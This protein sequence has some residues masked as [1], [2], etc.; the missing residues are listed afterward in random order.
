MVEKPAVRCAW[1]PEESWQFSLPD[2]R[3]CLHPDANSGFPV[4]FRIGDGQSIPVSLVD[5][6]F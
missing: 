4:S 1:N 6:I 5:H 2:A 3:C